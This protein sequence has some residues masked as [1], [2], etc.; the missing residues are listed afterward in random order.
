MSAILMRY[1]LRLQPHVVADADLGHDDADFGG[2][3][4]P[5]ALDALEQVAAALGVGQ[6]D[7][8]DADFDLHRVDGEVVFDPLLG[9]GL[10]GFGRLCRRLLLLGFVLREHARHA[11]ARGAEH[12]QRHARQ[13]G[14]DEDRQEAAG[15]G[16]RLRA[17]E[18][19]RDELLRQVR[20]LRAARDEQAG[21]ERDRG[22]P[23]PG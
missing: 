15:D 10:F 6:A 11:E 21:G 17:R 8:A 22:T 3:A 1:S 9:G 12:Q 5:H 4:L 7:Q 16:Q 23:A 18:E 2:D 13:V 14:G 19:L 20:L